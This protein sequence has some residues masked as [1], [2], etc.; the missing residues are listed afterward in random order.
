[1]P[2]LCPDTVHTSLPHC[3]LEHLLREARQPGTMLA[4]AKPWRSPPSSPRS[5]ANVGTNNHHALR[6][7]GASNTDPKTVPLTEE[8]IQ[9]PFSA[10]QFPMVYLVYNDQVPKH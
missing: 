10:Q 4:S 2:V 1:M 6:T 5:Q 3:N 7:G 8:V 9:S